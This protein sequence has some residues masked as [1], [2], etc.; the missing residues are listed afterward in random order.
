MTCTCTF[1]IS[2]NDFT[3]TGCFQHTFGFYGSFKTLLILSKLLFSINGIFG[4]MGL[5]KY[6][7]FRKT[8]LSIWKF[9]KLQGLKL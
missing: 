2:G 1:F 3:K 5:L 6:V 4:F 9:L 8:I 7:V